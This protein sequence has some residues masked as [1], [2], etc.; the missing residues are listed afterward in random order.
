MVDQVGRAAWLSSVGSE[1]YPS[2]QKLQEVQNIGQA[3]DM[4]K[5]FEF[6]GQGNDKGIS[7]K[8]L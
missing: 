1:G 5:K 4:N 8:P 7:K 3:V 6:N 2:M